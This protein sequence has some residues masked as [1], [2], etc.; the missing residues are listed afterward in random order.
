MSTVK[1]STPRMIDVKEVATILKVS[2]RTVWRLV[3]SG[4]LP[5]PIRFGR[6]VRWKLEDVEAWI[7]G[8]SKKNLNGNSHSPR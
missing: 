5:Q 2:K 1:I 4:E 7:E 6:N 3:A 8:L